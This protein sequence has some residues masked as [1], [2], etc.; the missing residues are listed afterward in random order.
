MIDSDKLQEIRDLQQETI[1]SD[2]QQITEFIVSREI[3]E[4][5]LLAQI[6]H[7]AMVMTMLGLSEGHPSRVPMACAL[8][9]VVYGMLI[10]EERQVQA[11]AAQIDDGGD[12]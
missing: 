11:F 4:D 8:F 3:D 5:G 9:G 2:P 6:S 7:M 10:A 12:A 1:G